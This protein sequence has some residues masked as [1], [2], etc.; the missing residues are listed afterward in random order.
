[1]LLGQHRKLSH[2]FQD[3]SWLSAHIQQALHSA[4]HAAESAKH[5]AQAPQDIL[6]RTKYKRGQERRLAIP[7]LLPSALASRLERQ[8]KVCVRGTSTLLSFTLCEGISLWT[9]LV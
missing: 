1:M 5:V 4:K 9:S 2:H 8:E 6:R 3:L 7:L